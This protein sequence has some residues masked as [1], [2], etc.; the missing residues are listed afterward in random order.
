MKRSSRPLKILSI[1][2]GFSV[3]GG[4]KYALAIDNVRMYA[5]VEIRSLCILSPSWECDKETLNE[6]SVKDIIYIR[7]RFDFSWIW[8]TI[9]QICWLN[10]DLIMSHGVNSHFVV[11]ISRLL[12]RYSPKRICSYHGSYYGPSPSRKKT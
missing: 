10:P 1:H 7:S 12:S 4:A 8:R 6:L 11:M 5:P 9:H 2:W 3:G